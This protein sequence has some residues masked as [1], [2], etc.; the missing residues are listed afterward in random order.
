[1]IKKK[2]GFEGQ[3]AI[4]LP[5][6]IVQILES[7]P[8]TAP[9]HITDI[10]FYP[11]AKHHFRE[12]KNG[13][14]QFILIFCV[15]GKG[16]FK[17]AS[18]KYEVSADNFF[19]L[20]ADVPHSY[21]ADESAPWSIYWLHFK[22]TNAEYLSKKLS[23]IYKTHPVKFDT[24]DD[25][26]QLFEEIYQTLDNGY[27]LDNLQ[28]SS[29]CLWHFLSSFLFIDHF[30]H[31]LYEK[32][33]DVIDEAIDYLKNNLS[34]NFSLQEISKQ[35]GVSPSHFSFIFKN[36]TGYPPLDYFSRLKIQ[37]ACQYLDLTDMRI[38]EIA[39]A[40]GYSDPFY[41]SRVF[42]KIMNVAPSHYKKKQKG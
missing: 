23:G 41:F 26:L 17:L 40:L 39:S 6:S 30:K 10:G 22:G 24:R 5:H 20:P 19:I 12:R 8:L 18:K 11:R 13:C 27:S 42:Q 9:L 29:M 36:K 1:M 34:N 21:G 7:N 4:V 28:Y 32:K 37:K 35:F 16:W 33:Y 31:F 3:K 25:R 38:K 15:G 14:K 2:D